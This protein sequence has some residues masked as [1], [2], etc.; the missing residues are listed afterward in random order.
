M[1]KELKKGGLQRKIFI[2]M[3]V[4]GVFPGLVGI[5]AVYFMGN[6]LV[7][8]SVGPGLI[9]TAEKAASEVDTIFQYELGYATQL[10]RLGNIREFTKKANEGYSVKGADK[11]LREMEHLWAT[12]DPGILKAVLENETALFLKSVNAEP[13]GYCHIFIA[14]EKGKIIASTDFL[15]KFSYADE[16][17]WQES[18]KGKDLIGGPH[19]CGAGKGFNTFSL[20]VPI[21]DPDTKKPI[22]VLYME[23]QSD[24]VLAPLKDFRFGKTGHLEI[25]DTKGSF[26]IEARG[27]EAGPAPGWL[28]KE[29]SLKETGWAVGVDEH[30]REAIKGFA[31]TKFNDWRV[32]LNQDLEEIYA[33]LKALMW[34]AAGPGFLTVLILAMIWFNISRKMI[35]RP[36]SQL[37][38]GADQIGRGHLDHRLDMKTGDEL[39][40][41]AHEFNTM[42]ENLSISQEKLERWNEDLR[43]EVSRRTSELEE[44][45]EELKE[46]KE[47]LQESLHQ[48]MTLN[49]ELQANREELRKRND[50]L[51]SAN[52][53]LREMDRLK[54]EF[55]AN[56]SH[57][58]RTPLT[59]IIGF[60]ELLID[61]VMGEMSEEQAGCVENILTSGQHLLKLINDILDLS[62][63][64]AGKME[65]HMEAFQLGT[66]IGFVK[67]TVSPLVERKGQT[68]KIEVADGIPD[69]YADPGKIKQLLLN[70]VGNAIKFTPDGGTITIGADFKDNYFAISVTDTGIGI[71]P[72]DREKIFQEFQQAEGS[73]SREYGGTGLGLTLTKRLTE[74][75]GG[76]IEVESEVGKGSK[77]IAFLPLR[78]EKRPSLTKERIEMRPEKPPAEGGALTRLQPRP[79]TQPL[80]LVVEDDQKLSRLL[81][82]YLNQAGYRVETA[83]DGEEAIKK[84]KEL[85]P[86]AITLD[87]MLP[88]KDGWV[89][90]QELKEAPETRNIP[91]I[92]VSMVEN[93]E[94]G[95]SLGAA[96]YLVKPVSRED[97]LESIG[98]CSYGTRESKG[99][100]SILVVDDDPK[101]LEF[102][103]TI[104]RKEGFRVS[105]ATEGE[106]GLR[107][108]AEELPDLIILDLMMPKVSG[109]E[110]IR[111]LKKNPST[112]E[113]PVLVLTAKDLSKEEKDK[114]L[115]D[116]ARVVQKGGISKNEL[117]EEIKK[118]EILHPDRAGL[119][120][121]IT[122]LFNHRY[123]IN[124]LSHEINRCSRY[125]RDLSISLIGIDSFRYY[126][127]VN[128]YLQGDTLLKEMARLLGKNLRK[129]D[130]AIRYSGGR[131]A[132]L[133][134]ETAKDAAISV[135][136]KLRYLIEG[137]PFPKKESQP[138]GKMTISI[139]VATCPADGDTVA[140]LI[141]GLERAVLDAEKSGG[142]RVIDVKKIVTG[143]AL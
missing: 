113:I 26:V 54:S 98:V 131:F 39:E 143:E 103:S 133:F 83:I 104:M 87:I 101:I 139:S 126:N 74:M 71:K 21:S 28:T 42:A 124:R 138:L 89:V 135:S 95:F 40:G 120:D 125:G 47:E 62:K 61:K 49:D 106:E 75:H 141:E 105:S 100:A 20:S 66:I 94:L 38:E 82:V 102:L 33:P 18:I 22:G 109:F 112:M 35:L 80:I 41:L 65:L 43:E 111:E 23:R 63:I 14:D 56:M 25:V 16:K 10:S 45:N 6:R 34:G 128:G 29:I 1:L 114:L 115:S 77:F 121:G 70:L 122:G 53:R 140:E 84:A 27:A 117:V 108:A 30:G 68:L 69:I 127:D 15:S 86:F 57:E 118:M 32:V 11:A 7:M 50:D 2:L 51:G 17:W 76:K 60:S 123:F 81:S 134:P 44:T 93:Q 129:A 24:K 48:V 142:N 96:D 97:L 132:V 73:T 110:V 136:D 88:K 119:V 36:I 8:Q 72:E 79:E 52:L 31:P 64:E 90:M 67:N 4:V 130:V 3:L 107:I 137:Y 91:V 78:T 13:V 92:I 55:L 5:T 46:S 19:P 85:Q 9:G 99:T 37:S 12:G 116:V 59:A 58:L